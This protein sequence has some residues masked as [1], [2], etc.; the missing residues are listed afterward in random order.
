MQKKWNIKIA[1]NKY[2]IEARRTE[3]IVNGV[4]YPKKECL[5]FSKYML[6]KEYKLPI[7]E[8][9]VYMV[10]G[11]TS[12]DVIVDGKYLSTGQEY[13]RMQNI[14]IW[15]WVFVA[16]NL[17]LIVGGAIGGVFGA[18]GALLTINTCANTKNSTIKKVLISILILVMAYILVYWL[19]LGFVSLTQY[20]Y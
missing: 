1:D 17:F 4:K 13:C 20:F 3:W 7:S 9:D 10:T 8:T 11:A 5:T 2:V 6:F 18:L 19:A 14:P 12:W 16:L 15:A